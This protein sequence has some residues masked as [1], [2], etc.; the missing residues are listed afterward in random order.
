LNNF[1][2][3]E[4]GPGGLGVLSSLL[5]EVWDFDSQVA[6]P[7][8]S[9]IDPSKIFGKPIRAY[10]ELGKPL[11][12]SAAAGSVL[13]DARGRRWRNYVERAATDPRE[14]PPLPPERTNSNT[15][16]GLNGHDSPPRTPPVAPQEFPSSGYTH[17][18]IRD[19]MFLD[20]TAANKPA[21]GPS[22]LLTPPVPRQFRARFLPL[23]PA[24]FAAE[25]PALPEFTRGTGKHPAVNKHLVDR[26]SVPGTGDFTYLLNQQV[27]FATLLYELV[28]LSNNP[29]SGTLFSP[30]WF[31]VAVPD[32]ITDFTNVVIYFH[33]TPGQAGY[34]D[35]DYALK[36]N[37]G[38]PGRTN[39]KEL[40]GYVDRLGSQLAGAVKSAMAIRNQVVIVPLMRNSNVVNGA[41]APAGI[42][43]RQ[44]YYIVNDIVQDLPTRLATL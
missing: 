23:N 27:S 19:F 41:S 42:L 22:T 10:Y 36:N 6:S 14:A 35:G 31:G 32:G 9:R 8:T 17:H 26:A 3:N 25:D 13:I 34:G 43:P 21:T 40:L 39:W 38:V 16:T 44:W 11:P 37:G 29:V 18:L 4:A 5:A 33:P 20:A 24:T 7:A 15:N 1:C 28:D 30:N 2:V 12:A